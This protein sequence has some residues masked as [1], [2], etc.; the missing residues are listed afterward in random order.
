MTLCLICIGY[1]R[2]HSKHPQ[3][4]ITRLLPIRNRSDQKEQFTFFPDANRS[5]Q[6]GLLY[7]GR[8][9][10][11]EEKSAKYMF[12]TS[13]SNFWV[14]ITWISASLAF[15]YVKNGIKIC[16]MYGTYLQSYF[17][18]NVPFPFLEMKQF[19]ALQLKLKRNELCN[20]A[21][22]R[23]ARKVPT[24]PTEVPSLSEKTRRVRLWINSS[25]FSSSFSSSSL[26]YITCF[27]AR[28]TLPTKLMIHI[29][30]NLKMKQIKE[31]EMFCGI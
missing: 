3:K 18:T 5:K 30:V 19:T 24:L 8:K 28:E 26:V 21:Q 13:I 14:L 16:Y 12:D 9:F 4:E 15:Y 29:K 6:T 20:L 2:G 11:M 7:S 1:L 31:M 22:Y 17:F 25:I 23:S 27:L 10:T